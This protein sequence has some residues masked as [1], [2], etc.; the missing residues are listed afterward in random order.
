MDTEGS[1]GSREALE[2]ERHFPGLAEASAPAV[3]YQGCVQFFVP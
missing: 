2:R 1:Q 3:S